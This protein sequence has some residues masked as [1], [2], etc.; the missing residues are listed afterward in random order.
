MD[1]LRSPQAPQALKDF[2]EGWANRQT[3]PRWKR[4]VPVLDLIY[5]IT[6]FFP[7]FYDDPEGQVFL[8]V[9]TRQL[10]ASEQVSKF[11]GR[12]LWE[13]EN[14]DLSNASVRELL[15]NFLSPIAS[16]SVGV[17]EELMETFPRDRLSIISIHQAKGLE[18]PLVIIDV[19]SEFKTNHHSQAFKRF[20]KKEGTSQIIENM[21]RSHTTLNVDTRSGGDRCFDDL[22]RQYFVAYS[23]PQEILLLVG[24]DSALPRDRKPIPNVALGWQRTGQSEWLNAFPFHSI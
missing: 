3:N 2:I 12:V 20:P 16:G 23:R 4:S 1:Y 11:K 13:S 9:F 18:F 7:A 10:S 22:Y 5:A 24:L 21:V 15:R 6:H 19:G 8:E 17:N 14:P